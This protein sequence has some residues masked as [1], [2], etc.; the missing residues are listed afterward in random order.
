MEARSIV[1]AF[2]LFGAALVRA[3]FQPFQPFQ[4]Q[5]SC[6]PFDQNQAEFECNS[7]AAYQY[8]DYF[9]PNSVNSPTP[10]SAVQN[11][12][13][14]LSL[15]N[16][17]QCEASIDELQQFLCIT[18]FPP[19]VENQDGT[20]HQINP[21]APCQT[22]CE[23]LQSRCGGAM[24]ASFFGQVPWVDCASIGAAT[25]GQCW[26]YVAGG[27]CAQADCCN[28]GIYIVALFINS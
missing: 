3:Q 19:C 10:Q 5:P 28:S 23:N 7:M 20:L 8:N 22:W 2:I 12:R 9:L 26:S 16:N 6:R 21:V 17:T 24:P 14:Y 27:L 4:P 25:P 11:A 1:F 13:P 18:F 15:Y